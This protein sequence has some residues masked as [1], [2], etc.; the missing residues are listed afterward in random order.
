[1]LQTL[2]AAFGTEL[3]FLFGEFFRLK[4]EVKQTSA[5][6]CDRSAGSR[7]SDCGFEGGDG[8]GFVEGGAVHL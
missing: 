6:H 4:L 3:P 8:G 2:T 7:S 1:M 5:C